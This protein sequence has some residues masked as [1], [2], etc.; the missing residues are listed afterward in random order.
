MEEDASLDQFAG[1]SV[2]DEHEK[3][4]ERAGTDGADDS[5]ARTDADTDTAVDADGDDPVTESSTDDVDA[6][7]A[8]GS[9]DETD[10]VTPTVTTYG[11]TPGG[12]CCEACGETAQRRWRDA[13]AMVCWDCKEW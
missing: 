1:A 10:G 13:D 4:D 2:A 9:L 8:S 6:E 12:V 11:W 7:P 3:R 5:D